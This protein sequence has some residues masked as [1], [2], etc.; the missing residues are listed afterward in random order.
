VLVAHG[1]KEVAARANARVNE[2]RTTT[3]HEPR[4]QDCVA[5]SHGYFEC[6]APLGALTCMP[7]FAERGKRTPA[8]V[9]FSTAGAERGCSD[10]V[11][12]ARGFAVRFETD[13]GVWDLVGRNFPVLVTQELT[14]LP[15]PIDAARTDDEFWERVSSRPESLHAL[16][17]AMSDW[18]LPRSYRM[19][20]GFGVHTFRLIDP[21][22]ES[23]LVKFHWKPLAGTH[24][25]EWS[26]AVEIADAVPDFHRRDLADAIDAGA[27]P[28]Y[29]LGVQIFTEDE[30]AGF[31]FDVLDPTKLVPEE[32]VPLTPVG[33]LVLDRHA[34]NDGAEHASAAFSASNLVPGLDRPLPGGAMQGRPERFAEH[35]A[36][37]VLFW[38]S[39]TPIE[40]AH[41][42]RAFCVELAQLRA[43]DVR[44][45]LIGMLA[46]VSAELAGG[47]A[48]GLGV[49][50]PAP[51]TPAIE[52]LPSEILVSPALSILTRAGHDIAMRRIA[53]LVADG[54]DAHQ[55]HTLRDGLVAE[56]ALPRLIGPRKG[57]I[58]T[59][60]GEA[61]EID[62]PLA[63]SPS[64]LYDAV[65]VPGGKAAIA[66]LRRLDAVLEFLKKQFQHCKTILAIDDADDALRAAGIENVL[67]SGERDPGVL[68]ARDRSTSI[69]LREFVQAIAEHRHFARTMDDR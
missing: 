68:I 7:L 3:K 52:D 2:R 65:V 67:P 47:V 15:N 23:R 56:H 30:A 40:K 6:D 61:L 26:E 20:P 11:R 62:A 35:Y 31:S 44:D 19:M 24:G 38:Q 12:A 18:A 50:R 60:D 39:Q 22:G 9:R 33:R 5:V 48:D 54:V 51:P 41:I 8:I 13:D 37:A 58:K 49:A 59:D 17:W 1:S 34:E 69:V 66:R 43:A 27:F 16:M 32:V 57:T 63:E 4:E 29:E 36:Q 25:L 53:V 42:V 55:V 46:N 10:S 64:V 45:R 28:E 14:K 21:H